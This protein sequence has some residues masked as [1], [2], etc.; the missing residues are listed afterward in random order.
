LR[1]VSNTGQNLRVVPAT[2]FANE[3]GAINGADNAMI[4][5]AAYTN[6]FAGTT[7]T[8][9]YV[10]NTADNKLYLQSPPNNGTLTDGKPLGTSFSASNGFDVGGSSNM[11]YGLFTSGGQTR[12]Y[13][14]DL[15]TGMATPTGEFNSSVSGFAIGLGF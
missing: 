12:L 10:V 14:V 3:D 11:A 13:A 5:A 2:G 15:M 8:A 7:T 9:L 6:N 1:I 4:T